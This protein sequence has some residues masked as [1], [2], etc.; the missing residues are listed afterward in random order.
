MNIEST[1]PRLAVRGTTY[2]GW[3]LPLFLVFTYLAYREHLELNILYLTLFSLLAVWLALPV[4]LQVLRPR[5][6]K[7]SKLGTALVALVAFIATITLLE[8]KT[9]GIFVW[10]EL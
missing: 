6:T 9:R 5:E 1:P 4:T 10:N 2:F 3:M 8:L 7:E